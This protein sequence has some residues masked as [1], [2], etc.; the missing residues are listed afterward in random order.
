LIAPRSKRKD[1]GAI[2]D[3]AERSATI[4]TKKAGRLWAGVRR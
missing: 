4:C 1:R 3:Y 2:S